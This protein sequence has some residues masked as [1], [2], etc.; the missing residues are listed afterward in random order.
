MDY[1][2]YLLRAAELSE[3]ARAAGNT[4]FGAVLIDE[5]GTIIEEQA[6]IEIT[7]K[8]CTGHAEC[9][10]AARASHKYS[11][12]FLWNCT[13]CT[14]VEPC[15][16]CTGAIYWANIGTIVYGMEERKLLQLTG[17]NEQNPTFDLPCREILA[18]GQKKIRVFGPFPEVE[19]AILKAHRGYWN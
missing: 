8:I 5:N 16:M 2:P 6:N 1:I 10:L 9:S 4:P 11:R 12:E 18:H 13:L 15:A 3:Q 17:N 7:E 14:S 19:A